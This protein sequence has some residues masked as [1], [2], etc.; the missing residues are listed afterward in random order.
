MKD[1]YGSAEQTVI[2]LGE[3]YDNSDLAISCL[4]T[5]DNIW[6][7]LK[8]T[9]SLLQDSKLKASLLSPDAWNAIHL[10]FQRPWWSRRWVI[11]EFILSK[12]T[13]FICGSDQCE[14]SILLKA[15]LAKD[16]MTEPQFQTYLSSIQMA[17]MA[18]KTYESAGAL[19]VLNKFESCNFILLLQ[20]IANCQATDPRDLLYALLGLRDFAGIADVTIRINYSDTILRV[21]SDLVRAFIDGKHDLLIIGGA[22]IGGSGPNSPPDFPSWVPDLG[23]FGMYDSCELF[24]AAKNTKSVASISADM[25]RLSAQGVISGTIENVTTTPQNSKWQ[26]RVVDGQALIL[27][28]GDSLHPTGIPRLQAYFRTLICD[29]YRLALCEDDFESDSDD[30]EIFYNMATAFLHTMVLFWNQCNTEQKQL[31]LPQ[32]KCDELETLNDYV[33]NYVVWQG[34]IPS[35]FSEEDIL[36]PFLGLKGSEHRLQWRSCTDPH[37]GG[38]SMW[39]FASS[40]SDNIRDRV[41]FSMEGGYFGLAPPGA[42]V[43]D[44]LCVLL[45]CALPLLIRPH[46]QQFQLV[47]SCYVYGM[48][49]GELLDE[50]DAGKHQLQKIELD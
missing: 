28:Q 43:G 41:F 9:P 39:A 2:W 37:R 20:L 16:L 12:S 31:Q 42:M 47:G 44:R 50:V 18:V 48:M 49:N 46:G 10:L 27:S 4:H 11:Q 35:S 25:R 15:K 32:E 1:I 29:S 3:T 8:E 33:Q 38:T 13:L 7:V 23:N 40:I 36:E 17:Q 30:A 5:W 22:G 6:E 34:V 14:E 24:T 45:G 26:Q 21:F 19:L